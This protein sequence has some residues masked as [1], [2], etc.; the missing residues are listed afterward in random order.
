MGKSVFAHI[1]SDLRSWSDMTD[2]FWG[3][4]NDMSSPANW[5][6]SCGG[7]RERASERERKGG[8]FTAISKRSD[9]GTESTYSLAEEHNFFSKFSN[10]TLI[11]ILVDDGSGIIIITF[12]QYGTSSLFGLF[13]NAVRNITLFLGDIHT[14]F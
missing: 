2:L 14:L 6:T 1:S 9:G 10:Q 7:E 13:S 3:S 11:W 8:I 5:K 12:V 4:I